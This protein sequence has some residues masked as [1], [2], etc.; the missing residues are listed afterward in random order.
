[1]KVIHFGMSVLF[2]IEDIEAEVETPKEKPV[3]KHQQENKEGDA[4]VAESDKEELAEV[5]IR[6]IR[7]LN[8]SSLFFK[9]PG[10]KSLK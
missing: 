4:A 2:R 3:A 8:N 1:M 7:F 9:C 10:V 5:Q 6:F